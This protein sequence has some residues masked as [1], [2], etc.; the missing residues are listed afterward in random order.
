[1]D[2]EL[3]L[4]PAAQSVNAGSTTS[5]DIYFTNNTENDLTY[6]TV[7]VASNRPIL[8]TN[9]EEDHGAIYSEL[10]AT[11]DVP[12]SQSQCI[13]V[14]GDPMYGTYLNFYLTNAEGE[15]DITIPNGK[16]GT[17]TFDIPSDMQSPLNFTFGIYDDEN[18]VY[19]AS[20]ISGS[21]D[22]LAM[23]SSNASVTNPQPITITT[24]KLGPIANLRKSYDYVEDAY[25]TIET[26]GGTIPT[27]K[28]LANLSDAIDSISGGG[29]VRANEDDDVLFID[30]DGSIVCSYSAEDFLQLT[31]LPA[32]PTHEG[33]ISQGWNWSLADAK[34]YVTN[35]GMIEIGQMYATASG[36]SEFDIELTSKTGKEVSLYFESYTT[37][38]ID[39]GDNTTPEAI[40]DQTMTHTYGDYGEYTIKVSGDYEFGWFFFDGGSYSSD[41]YNFICKFARIANNITHIGAAV[42]SNSYMNYIT[43]PSSITSL[44]FYTFWNCTGLK[45]LIIPNQITTLNYYFEEGY[46]SPLKSN[47]KLKYISL[48]NG[49]TEIGKEFCFETYDLKR[50][51]IPDSVT[52]VYN[53]SD[54]SFFTDNIKLSRIS[55]SNNISTLPSDFFYMNST[56]GQENRKVLIKLF[57]L[58]DNVLSLSGDDGCWIIYCEELDLGNNGFSTWNYGIGDQTKKIKFGSNTTEIRSIRSHR[59]EI[60]D[61][62]NLSSI[63]TLQYKAFG[64]LL[65]DVKIIVPDNLYS[66]WIVATNWV[67]YSDNIIPASEV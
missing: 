52:M 38:T 51:S 45:C 10:I 47:W 2:Y 21:S 28:N 14:I 48:P 46:S 26:K 6:L 19:A 3:R 54:Y 29:G 8:G 5:F 53:D 49:I 31:A 7:Y 12:G 13:S 65:P 23:D 40:N 62:T 25:D 34:T 32:N 9:P 64:D 33:L 11:S 24:V 59:I 67:G 20:A 27:D 50:L 36:A 63:P 58:K 39:W 60:L 55:F 66:Q 18:L 61:F 4:V 17:V 35:H 56:S 37:A 15:P 42:F 30:Y 22:D 57:K 44:G 1:M 16:I 43:L 41:Q